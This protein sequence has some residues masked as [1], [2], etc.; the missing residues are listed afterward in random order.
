VFPSIQK[1]MKERPKKKKEKKSKVNRLSKQDFPPWPDP[2]NYGGQR[3]CNL[4]SS[5]ADR[6]G[7]VNPLY[8]LQRRHVHTPAPY[9]FCIPTLCTC[10]YMWSRISVH[11]CIYTYR[12]THAPIS[13]L[14]TNAH[15]YTLHK[16]IYI[17]VYPYI[18]RYL[19][20]HT[21]IHML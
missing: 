15:I 16:H 6:F 17:H 10:E 5:Q 9:I 20:N 4:G 7:D 1:Y 21:E 14:C 8:T 11:T 12:Y 13:V 18:H 2:C 3:Y 19:H